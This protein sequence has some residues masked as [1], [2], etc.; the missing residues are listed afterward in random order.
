MK[1][2][3]K[4]HLSTCLLNSLILCL[5]ILVLLP[6]CNKLHDFLPD[7]NIKDPKFLPGQWSVSNALVSSNPA[8]K[9]RNLD[10]LL[11]NARG[12]AFT[13]SGSVWIAAQD[14]GVSTSYDNNGQRLL[15]AVSIPSPAG[16]AGGSPTGIVFNSSRTDFILSNGQAGTIL[17]VGLDGIIS[18]WNAQAGTSALLIKNNVATSSY[19]GL[20]LASDGGANFLYAS[21]FKTRRIDVY[22]RTFTQVTNKKFI[23]PLLPP[24]YSPFNI[25]A[26]G[27]KL[28]VAYARVGPDGKTLDGNGNGIVNIFG[29][30]GTLLKRLATQGPLNSPWG[31]ALAPAGVLP[32]GANDVTILVA[33]HGNG[34]INGYSVDGVF[35][36]QFQDSRGEVFEIGGIWAISFA[37]ATF[38]GDPNRP[39]ITAGPMQSGAVA[40]GGF[41]QLFN[42]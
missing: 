1:K 29:T 33:N 34:R 36:G 19:T 25:Q 21:N 6:A 30:D 31:I 13:N 3:A 17:F 39:Y 5:F 37:P 11:V 8:F 20:A 22:D 9:P 18:G 4:K 41:W 2:I 42:L 26:L 38:T 23:D 16:P 40:S 35:K 15:P 27:G 12:I 32:S 14:K 24:D 28:F 10:P 7:E